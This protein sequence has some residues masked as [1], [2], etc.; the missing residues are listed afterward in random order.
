M[1]LY[2]PHQ[3]TSGMFIVVPQ[4]EVKVLDIKTDD[5][6]KLIISGGLFF[7]KRRRIKTLNSRTRNIIIFNIVN[8]CRLY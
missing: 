4:S 3:S 2:L 5:A 8:A 1:F 7:Q 6:I